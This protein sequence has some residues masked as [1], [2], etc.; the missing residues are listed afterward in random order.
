MAQPARSLTFA[1][2]DL[3]LEGVLHLPDD[4]PAAAAVIC[5]PAP[6]F[7][8]DMDNHVV[9]ALCEALTE[10]GYGAL[11]FNVRGVGGSQGEVDVESGADDT[12]AALDHLRTL[13]EVDTDSIGLIGYS[14]GAMAAAGAATASLKALALVS[15]PLGYGDLRLEPG[16][17]VLVAC[18]DNDEY[19]P[20]DN[21]RI[22]GE[23]PGVELKVIAGSEH[24]WQG[25]QD[26]LKEPVGEFFAQ[27]FS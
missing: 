20:L 3:T 22:A 24:F 5:H 2:G 7:G 4:T 14:L 1:S 18:G 21:L 11:R 12:R 25:T 15:P 8:G 16:C 19:A 17:P 13:R 23:R 9:M 26:R 10:R 6:Q 27:H